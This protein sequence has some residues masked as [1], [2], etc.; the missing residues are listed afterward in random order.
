[1]DVVEKVRSTL[2]AYRGNDVRALLK[3]DHGTLL[4]MAKQLADASSAAMRRSLVTQ[5]Q[6]LLV[7]HSRA[8]EQ[9]VYA[10]L[11]KVRDS[12]EARMAGCEGAVEHSLADVV[13]G[14][15]VDTRDASTD[16]WRAHAKVLYA[17]LEH[18]IH[19][20]ESQVFEL[21]GEHFSDD[22]LHAMAKAFLAKREQLME[23]PT[24]TGRQ[25][26]G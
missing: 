4:E 2:G 8:E 9:A 22:E 25:R 14:R 5:L 26:T 23:V 19:E 24:P 16:I 7:A 6:P 3:A 17:L 13:L 11:T 15:L 20:E 21:L 18:H 1:M 10:A 12:V